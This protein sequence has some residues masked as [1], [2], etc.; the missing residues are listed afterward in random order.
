MPSRPISRIHP[1]WYFKRRA[2]GKWKAL[3]TIYSFEID[4]AYCYFLKSTFQNSFYYYENIEI[5]FYNL[6][7]KYK[8]KNVIFKRLE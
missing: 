8:G 3:D 6:E 7:G 1:I 5:D 4:M 2:A